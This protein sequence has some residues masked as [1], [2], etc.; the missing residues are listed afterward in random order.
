MKKV[1]KC[2]F[3]I[4][5]IAAAVFLYWQFYMK[6][7]FNGI[8]F[9]KTSIDIYNKQIRQASI[10]HDKNKDEL[11]ILDEKKVLFKSALKILPQSERNPEIIRCLTENCKLNNLKIVQIKINKYEEYGA[12]SVAASQ[13]NIEEAIDDSLQPKDK[14][15]IVPV[16]VQVKGVYPDIKSFIDSLFIDS[17]AIEL[18]E[19]S[20]DKVYQYANDTSNAESGMVKADLNFSFLYY[21]SSV[22]SEEN[23]DFNSGIYGK[24]NIFK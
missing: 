1:I 15:L 21:N 7:Y 6:V 12:V 10:I 5:F 16:E 22:N 14:M 17:R 9:S 3:M 13:N 19:G 24:W 2:T 20:F 8:M 18:S 4:F 11:K 23:Y